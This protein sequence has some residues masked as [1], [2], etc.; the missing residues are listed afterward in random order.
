MKNTPNG[1][2]R[3]IALRSCLEGIEFCFRTN[4]QPVHLPNA[5][6]TLVHPFNDLRPRPRVVRRQ[7]MCRKALIQQGLLPLL[8][9]HLIDAGRDVVPERLHVV[10]LIVDRKRVEPS[11]RQR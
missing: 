1:K 11:G 8:E 9:W 7:P 6:E 2:R 4:C 10:D 3:R 5:A